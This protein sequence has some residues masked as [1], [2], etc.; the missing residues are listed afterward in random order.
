MTRTV[1]QLNARVLRVDRSGFGHPFLLSLAVGLS[2]LVTFRPFALG[3]ALK[4]DHQL[5]QT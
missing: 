5:T 2:L 3:F 4:L 1:A